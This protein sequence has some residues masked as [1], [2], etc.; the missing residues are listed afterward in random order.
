MQSEKG[1]KIRDFVTERRKEAVVYPEQ[2]NVM[3][4]FRDE[5]CIPSKIRMVIVGQDPYYNGTAD[6]LAFSSEGDKR[7]ESLKNIFTELRND[8]YPYLK[9][10][11]WDECMPTN[12]LAK[13]ANQGVLLMNTV[14]TVE[15]DLP[16]SHAKIGWQDFTSAVLTQISL[17]ESPIVFMLWGNHARELKPLIKG[18]HH[19]ILEAAHPSPLSAS[20]GFFGCNHFF[21]ANRFMCENPGKNT[22][23]AVSVDL[24]P[25]VNFDGVINEV[26]RLVIENKFPFARA[27]EKISELH[28]A[29]KNDYFWDFEYGVDFL[30][31]P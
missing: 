11:T 14:L 27:N 9:P 16:N 3:R 1:K 21:E 15:K 4:A 26:K 5:T 20:K 29:L 31:K 30:T 18:N 13:W 7:P 6:G 25:F 23:H 10:E 22:N 19:L 8:L 28:E 24:R 12:S 17:N 2:H